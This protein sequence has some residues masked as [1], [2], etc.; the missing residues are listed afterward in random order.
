MFPLSVDWNDLK[1]F[2]AVAQ[3]GSIRAAS[4]ALRVAHSTVSRRIDALEHGLNTRLFDRTPDG[5]LITMAGEEFLVSARLVEETMHG[6]ERA[7][8]GRDAGLSGDV[9]FTLPLVVAITVLA[10]DLSRFATENPEMN[11]ILE[12]TDDLLDL[13]KREA[14]VAMRFVRIGNSPPDYLV[15][16][17]L[18]TSATCAYASKEY[19]ETHEFHGDNRNATWLGWDDMVE[20]P[21][22]VL[23][24]SLEPM[25]VKGRYN[26]VQIQMAFA[27]RGFGMALLPCMLADPDPDL[28]RVPGA[29]PMQHT[30]IWMLTHP[31]LRDSVRLRRF[32][33]FVNQAILDKADLFEGRTP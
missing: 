1:V 32:R 6:A 8:A 3:H 14:D 5:L 16:R 12:T 31:D 26:D 29:R 33:E 7:L 18:A 17:A 11:L 15:G 9:R 10:D 21:K 24:W 30:K 25:P 19:I 23:E 28:H 20:Y 27:R 2:L 4:D 13:S 22:W